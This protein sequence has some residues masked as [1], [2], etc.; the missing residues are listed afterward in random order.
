MWLRKRNLKSETES[1]NI[2]TN[3]IEVKID[4]KQ[5]ANVGYKVKEM[6]RSIT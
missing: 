3:Y 4:K 1:Q 2:K 5:I 6:K